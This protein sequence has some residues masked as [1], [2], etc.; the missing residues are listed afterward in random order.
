MASRRRWI[1]IFFA[2]PGA[3]IVAL[4]VMAGMA[5]WL[6]GGA[7]GIDN[8][9]LPLV[10]VPLI[11]AGLFFHACLDSSLARV[12]AV[13]VGLF[14]LHAGLVA[15]QFLNPPAASDVETRK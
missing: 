4:A 10:L 13:A 14:A 3:V 11:W 6:P 1:R 15:N 2:G 7:A 8:L 5:L 12:A 9:I